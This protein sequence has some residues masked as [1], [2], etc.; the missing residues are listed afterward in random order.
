MTKTLFYDIPFLE[1]ETSKYTK[2][3]LKNHPDG[4]QKNLIELS[5]F[6]LVQVYFLFSEVK[7]DLFP[8]LKA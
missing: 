3:F 6:Y 5:I 4:E 1:K 8:K 2:Y 7:Q